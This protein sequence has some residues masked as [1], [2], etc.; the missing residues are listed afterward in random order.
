MTDDEIYKECHKAWIKISGW[1]E[2]IKEFKS[3]LGYLEENEEVTLKSGE[4][5]TGGLITYWHRDLKSFE[6]GWIKA[7][8]HLGKDKD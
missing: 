8:R 7:Y 1:W 2:S 5:I 4:I 3:L 6:H